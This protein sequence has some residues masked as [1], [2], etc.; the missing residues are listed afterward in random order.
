MRQS[1]SGGQR[2]GELEGT[3]LTLDFK[4]VEATSPKFLFFLRHEEGFPLF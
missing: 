4:R 2:G 3:E 1:K